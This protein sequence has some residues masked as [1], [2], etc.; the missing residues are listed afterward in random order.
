MN[1]LQFPSVKFAESIFL[2]LQT[3]LNNTQKYVIVVHQGAKFCTL[4]IILNRSIYHIEF[5]NVF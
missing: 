5:I 3:Q 2:L 1:I 4:Q